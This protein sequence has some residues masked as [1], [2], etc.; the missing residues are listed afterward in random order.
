MEQSLELPP[1]PPPQPWAAAA[2]SSSTPRCRQTEM[3]R[4]ET[5]DASKGFVSHANCRL[6]P[7]KGLK[8]VS[9]R[10]I[11]WSPVKNGFGLEA[12][13]QV[14]LGHHIVSSV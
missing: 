6:E 10:Q 5:G 7:L 14:S 11:H 13:K 4:N 8:Y 12:R 2:P 9:E 3:S 1:V